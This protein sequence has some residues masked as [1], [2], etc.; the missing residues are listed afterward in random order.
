MKK[1]G[2]TDLSL[3]CIPVTG[4]QQA[5]VHQPGLPNSPYHASLFSSRPVMSN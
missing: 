1:K 5:G 3:Q 2:K 4:V